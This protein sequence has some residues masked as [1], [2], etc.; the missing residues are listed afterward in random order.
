VNQKLLLTV[1]VLFIASV[2]EWQKLSQ[3]NQLTQ[4]IE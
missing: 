2:I 3:L 1:L 4:A